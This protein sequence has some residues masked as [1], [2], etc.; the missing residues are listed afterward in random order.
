[1]FL[2]KGAVLVVA[3][4]VEEED[5]SVR[6]AVGAVC[7]SLVVAAAAAVLAVLESE[8]RGSPRVCNL[9]EAQD[10]RKGVMKRMA[11][12]HTR[13]VLQSLEVQRLWIVSQ[14]RQIPEILS[15]AGRLI[16]KQT[17]WNS[18]DQTGSD[19]ECGDEDHS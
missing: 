4:S 3:L 5:G 11:L 19:S 8:A 16:R 13:V 7:A 18:A 10:L 6:V 17:R 2:Q 1:M 15:I 9:R 14:I 12:C